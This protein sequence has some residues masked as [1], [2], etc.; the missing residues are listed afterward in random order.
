MEGFGKNPIVRPQARKNEVF[1]KRKKPISVYRKRIEE[2]LNEKISPIVLHGSGMAIP[3][4]LQLAS[5][6]KAFFVEVDVRTSSVTVMDSIKDGHKAR[7]IPA[8]HISLRN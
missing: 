3:V 8:I 6:N 1:V 4:V 5:Q 7:Q 2:L